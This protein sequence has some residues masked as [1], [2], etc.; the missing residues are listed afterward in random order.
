MALELVFANSA[1]WE[2]VC[3][4]LTTGWERLVGLLGTDA[5]ARPVA[6]VGCSSIHTLGMRYAID[7]AFVS[8][9]GHVLASCRAVPPARLV[10]ARGATY[11]L[12]R[13]T[14]KS[15]WPAVGDRLF[16]TMRE[17]CE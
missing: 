3:R 8:G 16:A 15:P 2:L 1:G 9:D 14:T 11:V 7:V 4:A 10:G 5:R 13:P 12:E 17:R 6:L